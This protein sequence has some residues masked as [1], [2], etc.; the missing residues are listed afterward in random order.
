VQAPNFS[1]YVA[2]CYFQYS[3]EIEKHLRHLKMV[4]HSLRGKRLLVA[5]DTNARPSLWSPQ[6]TDKRGAKLEDLIRAFGLQVLNDSAQPPTYWTARGLSLIEVTLASSTMSQ[7]IGDWKVRQDWTSSN[8]NSVDMRVRVPR[9]SSN[10]RETETNRFDT[11][12]ADWDQF[13]AS[14]SDLSKSQLEVLDL[15]SAESVELMTEKFTVVLREACEA[16]MPK[17][18]KFRKSNPW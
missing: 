17:K 14:L 8:H 7:F 1:F 15:L 9:E 2:S 11:R 5:L 4:C 13:S 3:D 18:R 6:R 12:P 10:N 16:S